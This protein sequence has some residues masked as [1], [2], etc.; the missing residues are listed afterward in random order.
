MEDVISH[1]LIA[2]VCVLCSVFITVAFWGGLTRKLYQFAITIAVSMV[3][4]GFLSPA[5]LALLLKPTSKH[6]N[7]LFQTFNAYFEKA[8]HH[9]MC[10][11]V[12]TIKRS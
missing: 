3:I 5:L 2:I 6:S 1:V 7:V 10:A 8:V 4:S 12:H 11:V 9:Y